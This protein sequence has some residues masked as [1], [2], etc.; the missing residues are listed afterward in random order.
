MVLR[1]SVT[2]CLRA[3]RRRSPDR[4][5][6]QRPKES[7]VCPHHPSLFDPWHP[8]PNTSYT[9]SSQIRR[10]HLIHPRITLW[11]GSR[12][13]PPGPVT[14]QSN[15]EE[16][17]GMANSWGATSYTNGCC[18][19]GQHSCLLAVSVQ[20]SPIPRIA[21]RESLR[22]LCTMPLTMGFHTVMPYYCWTAFPNFITALA[23]SICLTPPSMTLTGQRSWHNQLARI[24]YDWP[25]RTMQKACSLSTTATT[26]PLPVV[27]RARRS[28]KLTC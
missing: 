3:S 7:I 24:Q 21:T 20:S 9:L 15:Y 17:S 6:E 5:R 11:A 10:S 27:S 18:V 22:S 12:W 16:P 8:P 28:R 2:A 14:V 4:I 23:I 19:W 25:H 1:D 26:V 13:S